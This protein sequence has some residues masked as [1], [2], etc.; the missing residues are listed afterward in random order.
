MARVTC[1]IEPGKISGFSGVND[2]FG[3]AT[4]NNGRIGSLGPFFSTKKAGP[5]DLMDFEKRY[6]RLLRNA[7]RITIGGSDLVLSGGGVR[8]AFTH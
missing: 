1:R 4:I 8:A 7:N 6:L 3:E 5:R 2:Y